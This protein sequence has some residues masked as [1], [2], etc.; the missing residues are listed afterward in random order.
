LA[1]RVSTSERAQGVFRA[2]VEEA[3]ALKHHNIGLAHIL[4]GVLRDSDSVATTLLDRMGIRV[5]SV[6]DRISLLLNEE[7]S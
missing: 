1:D 4:L 5:Q 2:A 3:D 6:R 7:P